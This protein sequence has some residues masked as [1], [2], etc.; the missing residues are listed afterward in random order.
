VVRNKVDYTYNNGVN[1]YHCIRKFFGDLFEK[2]VFAIFEDERRLGAG[3][4][5]YDVDPARIQVRSYT[6]TNR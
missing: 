2:L 5:W 4:P 1:G 3:R 6:Q